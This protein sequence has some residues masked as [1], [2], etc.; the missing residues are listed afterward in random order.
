MALRLLMIIIIVSAMKS[1]FC[2]GARILGIF[3]L[4]GRSHF[5]VGEQLMKILAKNGH[6]VDMISHYPQ[7]K[8]VSNYNDLSLR[9]SITDWTNNMNYDRLQVLSTTSIIPEITN[10]TGDKLCKLLQHPILNNIIKNPPSDPP[11]DLVIVEV[12]IV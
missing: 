9:G 11:Y 7:K 2:D 3:P 12:I 10:N 6:Q 1:E 5:T 4:S 8:P